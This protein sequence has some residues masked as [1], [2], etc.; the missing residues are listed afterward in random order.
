VRFLPR[1]HRQLR[2]DPAA[3]QLP[4]VTAEEVAEHNTPEDLWIIVYGKVY[5][6]TEWKHSHPGG[7]FV[8]QE[9]GGKDASEVFRSVQHSPDALALRPNFMVAKLEKKPEPKPAAK[10]SKL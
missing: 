5:D 9:F 2:A 1:C 6:V 7:D 10:K 4:F 3:A 8:L